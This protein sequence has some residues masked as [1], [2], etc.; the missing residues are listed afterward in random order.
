MLV[1]GFSQ[2]LA[3]ANAELA[4]SHREL[5]SFAYIAAHDLKEPLRARL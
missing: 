5:D 1:D 4:R 3:T 2:R